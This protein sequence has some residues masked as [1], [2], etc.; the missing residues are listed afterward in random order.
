[1]RTLRLGYVVYT[2]RIQ[3]AA[4]AAAELVAVVTALYGY[5]QYAVDTLLVVE[6]LVA[7][8]TGLL[9]EESC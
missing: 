3:P 5:L 2:A 4:A 8:A 7:T 1:M 9:L 6:Q